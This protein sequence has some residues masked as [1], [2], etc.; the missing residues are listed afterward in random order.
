MSGCIAP[1]CGD[2]IITSPEVCDGTNYDGYDCSDL[3]FGG[4]T[5]ACN[6]TEC[7]WDF[8]NCI[9]G[10]GNNTI[11]GTDICDGDDLG[12]TT[13]ASSGYTDGTLTCNS[14][15]GSLDTSGCYNDYSI[16]DTF[17]FNWI[18]LSADASALETNLDDYGSAGPF[19]IGFDFKF[20]ATTFSEFHISSDGYISFG[21]GSYSTTNACPITSSSSGDNLIAL[22]WDDLDGNNTDP[23]YHRHFASCPVGSSGG[24]CQI[25]QYDNYSHYGTAL[26]GTFQAVLFEN[27]SILIQILDAGDE[28][29]SS[30]TTGILDDD[31]NGYTWDTC[32]SAGSISDNL[33]ICYAATGSTGC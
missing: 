18:D 3:G 31:G 24:Q 32:N 4:G 27:G 25:V 33:A 5:L 20:F 2:S 30:S 16:D 12:G 10:C 28:E 14:D 7:T 23:I 6:P 15:C 29:G 19:A 11:D 13:C 8:N 22:L 9:D 17:A 26:A 1:V 21:S